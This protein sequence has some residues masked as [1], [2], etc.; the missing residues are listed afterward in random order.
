M[1]SPSLKATRS[2]KTSGPQ[3]PGHPSLQG[4]EHKRKNIKNNEGKYVIECITKR[5]R[6]HQTDAFLGKYPI[7]IIHVHEKH[8]V[9]GKQIKNK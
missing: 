2:S 8:L 1:G 4:K 3:N 6:H 7:Y 9:R 5:Y